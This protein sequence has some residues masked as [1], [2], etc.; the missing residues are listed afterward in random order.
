MVLVVWLVDVFFR[1]E[2]MV[3]V[4]VVIDSDVGL[5]GFRVAVMAIALLAVRFGGK[6]SS[7]N[8]AYLP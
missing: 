8:V 4:I 3:N 6:A 5:L 7:N 1:G 2:G